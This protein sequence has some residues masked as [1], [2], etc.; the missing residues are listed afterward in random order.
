LLGEKFKKLEGVFTAA[1]RHV[2]EKIGEVYDFEKQT[3]KMTKQQRLDYHKQKS[4]PI[5]ENLRQW[6]KEQ[7]EKKAVN[8]ALGCAFDYF[9]DRFEELTQFSTILGAP[10]DNNIC[11]RILRLVVLHRNNSLFYR[12]DMGALVG[13]ICMSLISSCRLNHI[14]PYQYLIS[15][16]ENARAV[17]AKPVTLD[18]QSAKRAK[19]WIVPLMD[20]QRSPVLFKLGALRNALIDKHLQFSGGKLG[21]RLVAF[22]RPPATLREPTQN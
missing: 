1:C 14:D 2:I 16:I 20:R 10:L 22:V 17:R 21:N 18:A 15:I 12:N 11:E 8:D 5:M 3:L 7:F 6:M 19:N 4:L 9:L 13:D